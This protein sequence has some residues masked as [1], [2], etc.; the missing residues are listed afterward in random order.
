GLV[1]Q[2]S[3]PFFT[4]RLKDEKVQK[5]FVTYEEIR[6]IEQLELKPHSLIWHVRNYFLFAFYAGG[7]R[8]SDVALLKWKHVQGGRTRYKMRKTKEGAGV[9]LLP[10]AREI[11][12][13]YEETSPD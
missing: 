5:D 7:M 6:S 3:N 13:R 9:P 2:D 8:W 12:G 11:L 1:S 10:Q 4:V